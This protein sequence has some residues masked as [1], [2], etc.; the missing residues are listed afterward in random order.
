MRR[1]SRALVPLLL[2][3]TAAHAQDVPPPVGL[4]VLLKVVTYDAHFGA[5]GQGD[6]VVLVPHDADSAA[7]ARSLVETGGTLDVKKVNDRPLRFEAV[8]VS[9][10]RER[11]RARQAAA[12]LVPPGLGGDGLKDALAAARG[13]GAYPLALTEAQVKA[14]AA[15]G[16]GVAN[17]RPQPLVNVA[18][19]KAAGVE[20]SAAVL[21]LARA[22]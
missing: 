15:L 4:L 17:G 2:A 5:H 12:V 9:E 19:A 6:F 7:A 10:L 3:A 21:R 18:V 8:P 22:L 13:A 11:L 20:L 1:A 14:G 16:V